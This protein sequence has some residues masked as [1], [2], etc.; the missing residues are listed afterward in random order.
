MLI[1]AKYERARYLRSLILYPYL[2]ILPNL[3]VP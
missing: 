1:R 3:S 2:S